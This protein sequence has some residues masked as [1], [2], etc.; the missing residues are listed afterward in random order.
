MAGEFR[1]A[2]CGNC[3]RWPGYVKLTDAEIVAIAGHLGIS[4]TEFTAQYTMLARNR[5]FLSLI[6]KPDGSCV[7]FEAEP[8][9][10]RINPVKP[11]QCRDFPEKWNFPGWEEQCR[12]KQSET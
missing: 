12:G 1:C 3:C 2:R 8:V 7:F 11:Q 6:E 9:G 5:R 4:E 10:C